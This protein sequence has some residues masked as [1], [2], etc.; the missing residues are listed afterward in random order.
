MKHLTIPVIALILTAFACKPEKPWSPEDEQGLE[1]DDLASVAVNAILPVKTDIG[2]AEQGIWLEGRL[3]P[4]SSGGLITSEEIKNR[5]DRLAIVNISV[6]APV[7]D[8]LWVEYD[9]KV[10]RNFEDSPVV[11][12]TRVIT[13]STPVG[14]LA[15][16]LGK[17]AQRNQTLRG[18]RITMKVDLFSAFEQVPDSFLAKIEGELLLMPEGTD[19]STIDPATATSSVSSEAVQ[20]NLIRVTIV[21]GGASE[22]G[23]PSEPAAPAVTETV[24]PEQ[25]ATDPAAPAPAEA[26]PAGDS[27]SDTPAQ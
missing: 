17:E 13:E 12:R 5:R 21:P 16:V 19:E 3:A 1:A 25:P 9:V 14:T 18:Q 4:E 15:V 10:G 2:D 7:P 20:A 23:A 27:P 24:A 26:A 6:P 22:T 11:L 8:E